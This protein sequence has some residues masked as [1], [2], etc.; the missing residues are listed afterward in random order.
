MGTSPI[1]IGMNF[2]GVVLLFSL[3]AT[4]IYFAKNFA[5]VA[6]V[7]SESKYLIISQIDKFPN[8]KLS[9]Q[10]STYQISF[11]KMGESQAF[12]DIL[13]LNNPTLDSQTYTIFKTSGSAQLFFGHNTDNIQTEIAVPSQT[14]VPLSLYSQEGDLTQSIEFTI[15]VNSE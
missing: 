14:A 8:L 9:Q 1:K 13:I 6:G 11:T 10:G 3:I 4:P 12:L 5:K 2:L 15:T 7:K